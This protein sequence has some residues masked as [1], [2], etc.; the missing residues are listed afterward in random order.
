MIEFGVNM[1]S[2]CKNYEHLYY[3]GR[4]GQSLNL[5][6]CRALVTSVNFTLPIKKNHHLDFQIMTQN[7]IK[8]G[9][10]VSMWKMGYTWDKSPQV[11]YKVSNFELKF[12]LNTT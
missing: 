7:D 8:K 3:A 10:G 6:R 5:I 11:T 1:K 2:F 12:R 4:A 9:L